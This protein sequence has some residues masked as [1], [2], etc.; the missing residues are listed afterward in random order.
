MVYFAYSLSSKDEK[1]DLRKP[2]KARLKRLH[3]PD[4]PDL[5]KFVPASATFSLLIQMMVG[6]ADGEGEE[7]FDVQVCT[8]QWIES[9]YRGQ[10]VDLRHHIHVDK[11]DFGRI[12][13]RLEGMVAAC[14]GATWSEVAE[15]VGRIGRWEFEDYKSRKDSKLK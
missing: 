5:E 8:P 9:A 13:S 6:P 2:M 14:E 1:E 11:Y 4:V 3:S 7:S 12:K 10:V 15:K